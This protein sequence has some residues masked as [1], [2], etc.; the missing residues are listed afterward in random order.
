MADP[1]DNE[2]ILHETDVEASVRE[3]L[4][5]VGQV[6]HTGAHIADPTAPGSSYVQAEAAS[7][8]AAIVAIID[9]LEANGILATS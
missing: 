9:V 1:T 8:R 2:N 7:A 6:A 3:D 5:G 4:E